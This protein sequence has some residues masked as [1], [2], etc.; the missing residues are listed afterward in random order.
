M[1]MDDEMLSMKELIEGLDF[2]TPLKE[3]GDAN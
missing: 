3:T 2:K 1:S